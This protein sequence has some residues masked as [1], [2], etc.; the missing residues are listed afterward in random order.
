MANRAV[1]TEDRPPADSRQFRAFKW[2]KMKQNNFLNKV[3]GSLRYPVVSFSRAS[4]R[5]P[6]NK[7]LCSTSPATLLSGIDDGSLQVGHRRQTT[8][9]EKENQRQIGR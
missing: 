7:L 4:G 1:S 8:E 5:T 9:G 3:G 2:L 6:Q